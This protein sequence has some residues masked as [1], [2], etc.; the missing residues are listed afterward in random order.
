MMKGIILIGFMGAG[1]TT[2]GKLLSEKTGMEHIDFDDKIVEE[3]GMTI[4][5]YF[6]LHGE[7]AFRERET[8]VLKRY[9]DHD[10]VVSTGGG[11]VMR[12]ENREL[13]KQMAPVIY[14]QTKPE[15]FIPRLKH[16]HT[17]VRPLVVSKSPE[18]IKQV[19]E[20]RIPF[21]EE[22]ASLVVATDNR[23]PE[24]IVHEILKNI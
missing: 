17:T 8:N 16:D 9:L 12:S 24:E 10:Q 22:S 1:K 3:I 23:T 18:E 19:F 20:P 6:D 4:Q 2:V 11:I 21:Y 7:D 15:V 14:L 5:E 13:L